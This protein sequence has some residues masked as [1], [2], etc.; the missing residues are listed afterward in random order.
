MTDKRR[1]KE[2]CIEAAGRAQAAA[3]ARREA[4]DPHAAALAAHR[5]GGPS[6]D[7][8][9]ALIRSQRMAALERE[10]PTDTSPPTG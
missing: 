7:E 6:V 10:G 8:I 2:E 1:T 5:P 4:L 9:E 3:L